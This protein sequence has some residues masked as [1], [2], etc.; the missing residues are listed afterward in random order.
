MRRMYFLIPDID[1]VRKI[2]DDL[3]LARIEERRIHVI[4]KRDTVLEGIP[5]ANIVHMSDLVP[6]IGRGI[7][8]GGVAGLATGAF[9]A[10]LFGMSFNKTG[11]LLTLLIT[12]G[13]A[14]FGAWLSGMVGIS[15]PNSRIKHFQHAIESGHL[16]MLIDVP[17]LK[18]DDITQNVAKQ[19]PNVRFGGIEPEIPAF[20]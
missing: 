20:P 17:A 2:V 13:G 12:V 4:A 7:V 8:Y 11:G 15:I 14:A 16:L 1:T 19:H 6:A 10:I 18:M 5:Q 9:L 3:L